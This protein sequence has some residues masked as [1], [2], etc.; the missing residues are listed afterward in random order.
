MYMLSLNCRLTTQAAKT[1]IAEIDMSRER[2]HGEEQMWKENPLPAT[3]R[4]A[5]NISLRL[6]I[7]KHTKT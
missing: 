5:S 1:V 3:C 2:H 7:S 6:K 4:N